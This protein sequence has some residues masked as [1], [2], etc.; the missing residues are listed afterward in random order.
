MT[1]KTKL[2]EAFEGLEDAHSLIWVELF[3]YYRGD[4]NLFPVKK[5]VDIWENLTVS[6][7][8]EWFAHHGQA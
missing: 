2:I 3:T 4:M 1:F 5:Y 8:D 7:Q 6:Q